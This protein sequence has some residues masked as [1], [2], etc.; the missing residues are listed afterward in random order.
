MSGTSEIRELIEYTRWANEQSGSMLVKTSVWSRPG[1]RLAW[2]ML[3]SN[4]RGLCRETVDVWPP[5]RCR[6][7]AVCCQ[8]PGLLIAVGMLWLWWN[9]LVGSYLAL[10]WRSRSQVDPG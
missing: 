8:L 4:L 9:R 7:V 2:P 10:T 5:G 1:N 3:P 6:L